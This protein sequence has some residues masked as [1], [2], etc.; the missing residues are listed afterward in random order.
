MTS[1]W[2]ALTFFDDLAG[3][4]VAATFAHVDVDAGLGFEGLGE[5]IAD[6]FVLAVVGQG[7]LVGRVGGGREQGQAE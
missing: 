4:L 6:F 5:F 2:G 3:Q 7:D 1:A